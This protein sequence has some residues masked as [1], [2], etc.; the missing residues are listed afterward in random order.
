MV[1]Y[2]AA[3]ATLAALGVE[4]MSSGVYRRASCEAKTGISMSRTAGR[5]RAPP[6]LGPADRR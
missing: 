4:E 2:V 6:P 1:E 3:T 5:R